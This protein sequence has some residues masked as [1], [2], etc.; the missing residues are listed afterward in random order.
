[1]KKHVMMISLQLLLCSMVFAQMDNPGCSI[2]AL[3]SDATCEEESTCNNATQC[4]SAQF[5]V[6]CSGTIRFKAYTTC[7]TTNCAHCASCVT[8]TTLGGTPLLAFDSYNACSQGNC[9][10]TSSLYLAAG[11]YLMY[12][13]L[14]PCNEVDGETCCSGGYNC[15]AWGAVSSNSLSCP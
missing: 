11:N 7:A 9:C 8:I 14:V 1:M 6:Q 15:V 5:K 4:P 12:V 2:G 3:Q 10:K 13:C